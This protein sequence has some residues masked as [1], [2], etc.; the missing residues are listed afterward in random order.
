MPIHSGVFTAKGRGAPVSKCFIVHPEAC[1]KP[2]SG[3]SPR[4]PRLSTSECPLS[5]GKLQVRM[6]FRTPAARAKRLPSR[7]G[8]TLRALADAV[9]PTDARA[10]ITS[11]AAR[12]L[13]ERRMQ[14][15]LGRHVLAIPVVYALRAASMVEPDGALFAAGFVIKM[16]T[17]S[18]RL[19]GRGETRNWH[20][21]AAVVCVGWGQCIRGICPCGVQGPQRGRC[22]FN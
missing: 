13:R 14:R 22:L 20:W 21:S 8:A 7:Q 11:H 16:N 3:R 19:L 12:C 1:V 4:N 18:S 5:E 15:V 9:K 17:A 6:R 2:L 10:L